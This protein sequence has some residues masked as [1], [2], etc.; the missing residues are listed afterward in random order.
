MD[1]FGKDGHRQIPKFR[2]IKS[3]ESW[4]SDQYL[5]EHM[6]WDFGKFCNK[7]IQHRKPTAN[8]LFY[9]L[10]R[11]SPAPL[12]KLDYYKKSCI[13][14]LGRIALVGRRLR[15][16]HHTYLRPIY[17]P[18]DGPLMVHCIA[19]LGYDMPIFAIYAYIMAII[20]ATYGH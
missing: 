20:M 10:V 3:W 6:K 14:V 12:N 11:E 8:T 5:P 9:F 18:I 19:I 2:L 4:I 15:G 13:G 17:V 7:E 16:N 1:N